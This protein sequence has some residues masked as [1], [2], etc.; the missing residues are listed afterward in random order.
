MACFLFPLRG[1]GHGATVSSKP[2]AALFWGG[3]WPEAQ[4]ASRRRTWHHEAEIRKAL[5]CEL[6]AGVNNS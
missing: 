4:G 1:T 5:T 3:L 6:W 2:M